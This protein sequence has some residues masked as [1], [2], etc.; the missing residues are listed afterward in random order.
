MLWKRD[1]KSPKEERWTFSSG[2]SRDSSMDNLKTI[3]ALAKF[4]LSVV[5]CLNSFIRSLNIIGR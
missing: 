1:T 2:V 5:S 3:R 4:W